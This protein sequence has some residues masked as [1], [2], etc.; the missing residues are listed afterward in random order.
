MVAGAP[1]DRHLEDE[2]LWP[3]ERGRPAVVISDAASRLE[4][5]LVESWMLRVLPEGTSSEVIQ[6]PPSRRRKP[7]QRVDPRL[8]ARLSRGDNP[9]VV[10]IRVV[11]TI[12]EGDGRRSLALRDFLTLR[13]PRDPDVVTQ[14]LTLRRHP[15][16]VRFAM[17]DPAGAGQLRELW[18]RG[19]EAVSFEDFVARRA[20]LALERAERRLRGTRYKIPKFVREEILGRGDYRDGLAEIATRLHRPLG[21]MTRKANRYLKEIAASHSPFVIDLVASGIRLLYRQG[22]GHID[23]DATQFQELYTLGARYPLV[24]LPSHK[25][26]LDH[27]VLQFLLWENNLPPNHTAGGI[28]MNFFPVGPLIRRTGVFFIRRTFK[29]NDT[30]K[31]VLRS[32]IEYLI[33]KRFPLEWYIEGGRSRSGKLLPPRYGM[34]VYVADALRN[35]RSDDVYLIPTAIA[36]DHIQEIGTYTAEQRGEA[37][38][39]ES[40]AWLIK[41]IRS[42]RKRYGNIHLRFGE[43]ISLAKDLDPV[44]EGDARHLAI[45]KVAFEVSVRINR[46]TPITPTSLATVAL[47]ADTDRAQSG[48]ELSATINELVAEIERRSLPSTVPLGFLRSA[49]GV[50][51]VMAGLAEHKIVEITDAGP[52]TV[53]RI[54][55]DA[56]LGA[57][58]YRNTIIHFFVNEAIAELAL[59]AAREA[60]S[61]FL[62]AFW[63][64]VANLRD[65]LKFEFFFPEREEF[66]EEIHQALTHAMPGW[67][68]AVTDGPSGIDKVFDNIR[69]LHAPWALRSFFEAYDIV[70]QTL[71]QDPRD[72][73]FD[74]K[75]FFEA[76]LARGKQYQL[77]RRISAPDAVS[78]SLFKTAVQLAENR[79]LIDESDPAVGDRR[80]DF[81]DELRG[82]LRRLG[83]LDA[84]AAERRSRPA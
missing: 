13:D 82:V 67:E 80:T 1:T 34:L 70:G 78:Q 26:N 30:Y 24:F 75:G 20:W 31:F 54:V 64:E 4:S 83:E 36:Y 27:L 42:L 77:Q 5:G 51:E 9:L 10:P 7:T 32:Y 48:A 22:Y 57:S 11:W 17:G 39:R 49:D 79:D 44:L 69:P 58:F 2:P 6:I 16:R 28:N 21:Q 29:D 23:Y 53:Y 59:A 40:A 47:L 25:S 74:E 37:K 41:A 55:V 65:L 62:D 12:D 19:V 66:R 45:Q 8:S 71:Q 72:G 56:H 18:E 14:H 63:A 84:R 35:G 68:D 73:S 60:G 33:E 38:E 43:P 50:R 46:A 15:D 61:A 76:A 81:A 52:D 3:G